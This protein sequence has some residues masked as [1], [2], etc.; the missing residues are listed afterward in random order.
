[1]YIYTDT[2]NYVYKYGYIYIYMYIYIYIY[3]YAYI[4][5]TYIYI[6][7]YI[8]IYIYIYVIELGTVRHSLGLINTIHPAPWPFAHV[9]WSKRTNMG[10]RWSM[11]IQTCTVDGAVGCF[12]EWNGTQWWSKHLNSA[13]FRRFFSFRSNP[14]DPSYVLRRCIALGGA[15]KCEDTEPKAC[16]TGRMPPIFLGNI[17]EYRWEHQQSF[18]VCCF[19]GVLSDCLFLWCPHFGVGDSL[20]FIWLCPVSKFWTKTQLMSGPAQCAEILPSTQILSHGFY[21]QRSSTIYLGCPGGC[22]SPWNILE[23]LSSSFVTRGWRV[24]FKMQSSWAL[25]RSMALLWTSNSS[26]VR[27]GASAEMDS[28][29]LN[30]FVT[31]PPQWVKSCRIQFLGVVKISYK[32]NSI[33]M[34][35]NATQAWWAWWLWYTFAEHD[36]VPPA[37]L[38][39]RPW[40]HSNCGDFPMMS[41]QNPSKYHCFLGHVRKSNVS[42]VV[43]VTSYTYLHFVYIC[44][45]HHIY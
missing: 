31:K 42:H 40:N 3:I 36:P 23:H 30:G 27:C 38:A 39:S 5:I 18:K 26:I 1:M 25:P 44:A 41:L 32:K 21:V 43:P 16:W 45:Y 12:R 28:T 2:C 19:C 7:I 17:W 35:Q 9:T 15:R 34:S 4:Y 10:H 24:A 22:R 29:G 33:G 8:Y 37:M 13:D 20:M 14:T 6:H 11:S